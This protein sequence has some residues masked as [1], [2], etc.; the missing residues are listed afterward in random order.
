[1]RAAAPVSRVP[2]GLLP[3][4]VALTTL[5]APALTIATDWPDFKPGLWRFDRTIEGTGPHPQTVERT[6]C[7]DPTAAEKRQQARLAQAGCVYSPVVRKGSTYQYSATCRVGAMTAAS[8]ST[9]VAQKREAY[10]ITIESVVGT[11]RTREVLTATR[12]GDCPG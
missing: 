5:A 2:R 8:N 7:V 3:V 1:M 10:T 4:A 12:L 11:V 6:E 9:L